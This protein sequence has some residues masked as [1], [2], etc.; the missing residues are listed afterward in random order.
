MLVLGLMIGVV[1]GAA[2]GWLY[3]KNRIAGELAEIRARS[4]DGE[5]LAMVH[6]AESRNEC[7]AA[8]AR[9]EEW[10]ARIDGMQAELAGRAADIDAARAETSGVRSQHAALQAQAQEERKSAQEKLAM[11]QQAE[12]KLREAFESLSSEALRKNNQSFLELAKET[13]GS[14]QEQ[15]A[16]DLARRQQA[17][18]EIVAPIRASLDK[19]D[20]KIQDVEKARVEAYASLG[21][22][23][24]SLAETQVNLQ[25]ETSNLVKALRTPHVRGRWGEIQLKRVVE[26]AGMLEHCDFFEQH[27]AETED[28]RFRPD[29]LVRLPG[30]KSVVVDAKAPLDAY[31][32]A[33]D[34]TDDARRDELLAQHARQVRDH[35]TKLSGKQ[36]WSQFQST[37]EFVCM[38]LPGETFFSAALQQD[39]GMIEF[40]AEQRVIVA[41]PT[42]LIA[43]L[44][45]VAYGW[46][47]EKIAENAQHISALGRTL[48]ERLQTM[49]GHFDDLRRNLDRTVDAYNR[50]AGSLESRVLVQARRFGELGVSTQGELPE[51]AAIDRQPRALN[52]LPLFD[53][54]DDDTEPE[55]IDAPPSFL[56]APAEALPPQ[57]R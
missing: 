45:A 27:T 23:V 52:A 57:A 29:L 41:S 36:Y 43:L 9:L 13:L 6:L 44:R 42:T 33:L 50:T 2:S 49:A 17:I 54:V 4:S 19:F 56:A 46:R 7:A 20:A 25:A 22:Q 30:G 48:Y 51:L 35:I 21:Q 11:L 38:F 18:G 47:Q 34:A 16:G 8:T 24:R 32:S 31:L 53:A 10:R 1:L 3:A 39:P 12:A 55:D 37:P 15:A 28:G 14:F 5:R 40:G 26:M